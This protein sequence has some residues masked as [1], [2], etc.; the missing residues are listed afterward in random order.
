MKGRHEALRPEGGEQVI[1]RDMAE[2]PQYGQASC[3][4][5]RYAAVGW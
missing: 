1:V 5:W 4:A 2:V 3:I